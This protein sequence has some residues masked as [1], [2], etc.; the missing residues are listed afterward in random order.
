MTDKNALEKENNQF[1]NS[2][3]EAEIAILFLPWPTELQ[4]NW[5]T[6]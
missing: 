3:L 5:Q 4:L 2:F 6:I 1:W